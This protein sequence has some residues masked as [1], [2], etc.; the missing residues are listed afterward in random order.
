MYTSYAISYESRNIVDILKYCIAQ[1]YKTNYSAVI[2]DPSILDALND[3]PSEAEGDRAP[4]S[5]AS[6][7]GFGALF[8]VALVLGYLL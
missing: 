4:P 1:G 8:V 5:K 6:T 7:Y 3:E 2:G